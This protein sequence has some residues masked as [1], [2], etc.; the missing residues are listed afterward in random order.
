MR[1][2]REGK[3]EMR[4]RREREMEEREEG[5]QKAGGEIKERGKWGESEEGDE[6]EGGKRSLT[7]PSGLSLLYL[8]DSFQASA[9]ALITVHVYQWNFSVLMARYT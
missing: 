2:G 7:H 8:V 4:R 9:I 3:R 1:K 6:E 5:G